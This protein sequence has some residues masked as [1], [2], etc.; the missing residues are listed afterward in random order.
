MGPAYAPGRHRIHR[1]VAVGGGPVAHGPVLAGRRA[2]EGAVAGQQGP[3]LL[4]VQIAHQGRVLDLTVAEEE[5]AQRFQ[6][7]LAHLGH[8]R[9]VAVE[10]EEE[11]VEVAMGVGAHLQVAQGRTP[12]VQ[13]LLGKY[14]PGLLEHRPAAAQGDAVVV[15]ELGV[16]GAGQPG[17]VGP[18]DREQGREHVAQGVVGPHP[19]SEDQPEL[20]RVLARPQPVGRGLLERVRGLR[21]QAGLLDEQRGQFARRPLVAPGGN[22]PDPDPGAGCPTLTRGRPVPHPL[23]QQG[24][25][26]LSFAVGADDLRLLHPLRAHRHQGPDAQDPGQR[27]P[28]RARG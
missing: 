27:A 21:D 1:P 14:P 9:P 26:R 8:G 15:E 2:E 5:V 10:L 6:V 17:L 13:R 18:H 25:H 12:L 7:A 4:A 19:G 11:H 24:G 3:V 28:P 23:P 22:E 16:G 20:A